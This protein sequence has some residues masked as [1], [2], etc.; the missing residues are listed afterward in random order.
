MFGCNVRTLTGS[1]QRAARSTYRAALGWGRLITLWILCVRPTAA[2]A[3]A[4][5]CTTTCAHARLSKLC[6]CMCMCMYVKEHTY[7]TLSF[8][9]TPTKASRRATPMAVPTCSTLAVALWPTAL[10]IPTP[11]GGDSRR[12][13]RKTRAGREAAVELPRPRW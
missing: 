9:S 6:M 3:P 4:L 1:V 2:P 7:V 12:S 11:G 8:Y 5:S 13:Y 10:A